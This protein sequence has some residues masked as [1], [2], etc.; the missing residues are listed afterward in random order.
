MKNYDNIKTKKE[1]VKEIKYLGVILSQNSTNMPNIL[2]KRNKALGTQKLIMNLVKG[3]GSYTFECG[4]IYLRSLLRGSILYGT[5]IMTHIIEKEYRTIEQIEEEQ[6]RKLF[7]TE[8]S[9][10]LHIMY[11]EG[12]LVPAWYM[13]MGNMAMFLHYSLQED[14]DS[15][16]LKILKTQI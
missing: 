7:D 4:F 1:E 12:G 15:L 10:P 6:M 2:S 9:C 5:E 3:L 11:L 16:L 13:I 14:E 8:R